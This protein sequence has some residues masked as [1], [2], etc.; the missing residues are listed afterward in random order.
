MWGIQNLDSARKR[1]VR[2]LRRLGLARMFVPGAQRRWRRE[3][4]AANN[5]TRDPVRHKRTQDL[6]AANKGLAM[7]GASVGWVAA[8]AD[9]IDEFDKPDALSHLTFPVVVLSAE[10]ERLVDNASHARIAARLPDAMHVIIPEAY[11]EIMMETDD[12]RAQFWSVFDALADRVAPRKA[13]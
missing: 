3:D 4:F 6:I 5:V 2:T 9:A 8:S 13:A 7:A 11:H 12:V 1:F 10:Q